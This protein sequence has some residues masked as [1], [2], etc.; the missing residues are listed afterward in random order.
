MAHSKMYFGTWVVLPQPVSPEMMSTLFL[1][2][3]EMIYCLC[4]EIGR[5]LAD[6]IDA[7]IE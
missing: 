2:S 1:S 5:D 3:F 6:S 4:F 7:A